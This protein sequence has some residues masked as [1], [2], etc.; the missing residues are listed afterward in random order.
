MARKKR[1]KKWKRQR[2]LSDVEERY[3]SNNNNSSNNIEEDLRLQ[4]LRQQTRIADMQREE[5]QKEKEEENESNDL[6]DENDVE[7]P[8]TPSQSSLL[9]PQHL[10][11]KGEAI[12]TWPSYYT[13][14]ISSLW[15]H[16]ILQQSP[17]LSVRRRVRLGQWAASKHLL[18]HLQIG[19]RASTMYSRKIKWADHALPNEMHCSWDM[20]CKHHLHPSAR[21]LDVVATFD[22]PNS[23]PTPLSS[24][25]K[26]GNLPSVATV[27]QGGWGIFQPSTREHS[28]PRIQTLRWYV[29]VLGICN[30][31]RTGLEWL[32][33][34]ML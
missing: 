34:L 19:A 17:G 26:Q 27:L 28:E 14:N 33:L 10:M 2:G 3:S 16:S 15:I 9:L 6:D 18:E 24:R 7:I 23:D 1:D 11:V 8:I 25:K 13:P 31:W 22:D 5:V 30:V 29:R 12:I 4:R 32:S 21:T 20:T